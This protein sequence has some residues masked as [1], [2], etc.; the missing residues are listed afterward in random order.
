MKLRGLWCVQV[1]ALLVVLLGLCSFPAERFVDNKNGTVTDTKTGL[2]W[3]VRDNGGDTT[4][5]GAKSYCE[6]YRGGGYSD[7]RMPTIEEL[8]SLYDEAHSLGLACGSNPSA[9]LLA[10]V[11]PTIHLSCSNVWSSQLEPPK[12]PGKLA[13]ALYFAFGEGKGIPFY[14]SF[15]SAMRALPVRAVKK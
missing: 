15:S 8:K 1:G 7:W 12:Q 14:L 6:N 2:M 5:D 4:W 13:G 3:A 10:R 11:A 9:E